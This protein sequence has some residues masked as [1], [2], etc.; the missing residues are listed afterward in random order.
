MLSRR[1]TRLVADAYAS[2]FGDH[3]SGWGFVEATR[4]HDFLYDRDFEAWLC[5]TMSGR[6]DID[7]LRKF[8]M[9]LHT[10]ESVASAVGW[11]PEQKRAWG[12]AALKKLAECVLEDGSTLSYDD[13]TVLLSALELDGYVFRDGKLLVSES[14]TQ[15]VEQERG[16]L[17]ALYVKLELPNEKLVKD[18]LD[19]SETHYNEGRPRDCISNARHYLELV[20]E[21]VAVTWSKRP[22]AKTLTLAPNQATAG[23]VRKYLEEVGVLT[24]QERK[25]F[26]ELYSLLSETGG[27]PSMS[28]PDQARIF[29]RLSLSMALFVLLRFQTLVAGAPP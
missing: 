26:A 25:T 23:P 12:Q 24:T 11:S 18:C 15:D 14:E 17:M 1:T 8:I 7:S 21:D 28:E 27:H 9:G 20:L 2:T 22:G 3:H 5:T 29:R 16:E 13:S 4:L 6:K 19:K 10:S